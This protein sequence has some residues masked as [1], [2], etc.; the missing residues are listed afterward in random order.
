MPDAARLLAKGL[1][2]LRAQLCPDLLAAYA[3]RWYWDGFKLVGEPVTVEE[4]RDAP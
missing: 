1:A 4:F 3:V 2:D